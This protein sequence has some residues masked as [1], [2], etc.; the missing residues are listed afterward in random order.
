M[1]LHHPA[2]VDVDHRGANEG[3]G[4]GFDNHDPS[5]MA[6]RIFAVPDTDLHDVLRWYEQELVGLGWSIQ[7][8]GRDVDCVN[9]DRDTDE[10]VQVQILPM[11]ADAWSWSEHYGRP[12]PF[13]RVVYTVDGNW[14]AESWP[15]SISESSPGRQDRECRRADDHPRYSAGA[16]GSSERVMIMPLFM[17]VHEKVDGLTAD[18]VAAAHARDVE[19]QGAY[20]VRYM[21]YWFDETSGKVFCLVEA[22]DAETARLV[23]S[24]AHG[25]LADS[26]TE[27]REGR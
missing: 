12:G 4:I 19:V 20:G 26:I 8:P 7:P 11:Q 17:D 14:P 25:L 5:A 22:P 1:R 10:H 2:A 27:V 21:Q 13:A 3:D 18:A 15:S 24:E 16:A 6:E 23:H 9:A